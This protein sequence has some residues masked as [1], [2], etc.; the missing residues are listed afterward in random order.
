MARR[1]PPGRHGKTPTSPTPQ[2]FAFCHIGLPPLTPVWPPGPIYATTRHTVQ[3]SPRNSSIISSGASG[4]SPRP[5]TP[6]ARLFCAE[7]PR[8]TVEKCAGRCAKPSALL[9]RRGPRRASPCPLGSTTTWPRPHEPI[10]VSPSR[11]VAQDTAAASLPLDWRFRRAR[12][13]RPLAASTT[14]CAPPGAK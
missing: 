6:G 12:A 11:V 13:K 2:P 9:A 8:L 10:P 7:I 5:R 1:V 3:H 4:S 14:A